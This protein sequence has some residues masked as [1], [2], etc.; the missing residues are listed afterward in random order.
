MEV[1]LGDCVRAARLLKL[2]ADLK[3]TILHRPVG[4]WH[5]EELSRVVNGLHTVIARH[6][7]FPEYVIVLG[8]FTKEQVLEVMWGGAAFTAV[9]HTGLE[10]LPFNP[11]WTINP[12]WTN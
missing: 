12:G 2:R 4:E 5:P 9:S 1:T 10:G 3:T 6:Y 11:G 8:H 7:T